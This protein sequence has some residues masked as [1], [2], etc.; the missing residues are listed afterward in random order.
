VIIVNLTFNSKDKFEQF[1]CNSLYKLSPLLKLKIVYSE[2]TLKR[3]K[4]KRSK[5]VMLL[6]FNISLPDSL[7]SFIKTFKDKFK[8]CKGHLYYKF[9]E[10]HFSKYINNKLKWFKAILKRCNNLIKLLK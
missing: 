7:K 4:Y 9:T 1:T 8:K 5:S 3:L 10:C 6:A 2:P